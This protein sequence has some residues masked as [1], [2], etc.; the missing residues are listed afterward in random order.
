MNLAVNTCF[1]VKRWPDPKDWARLV[2]DWGVD[3]VQITTDHLD[4][5]SD[6]EPL[7]RVAKRTVQQCAA[8]GIQIL[9]LFHG[10]VRYQHPMLL[11][12][13]LTQRQEAI[14]L[15]MAGMR[16]AAQLGAP[17]FGAYLGAFGPSLSPA[18]QESRLAW[19]LESMIGLARLAS[20]M[21]LQG[22]LIEPTPV[23][24]E[25]PHSIAETEQWLGRLSSLEP[26][27][28]VELNLDLGHVCWS[29]G[30]AA[31]RDV[32]AWI[33]ALAARS[34][35]IHLQQTDG[36]LDRHWPFTETHQGMIDPMQMAA[37]IERA[38]PEAWGCL[39]IFHAPEAPDA[40]VLSDWRASVRVWRE[41]M[42]RGRQ[43]YTG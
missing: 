43:R 12:D 27:V 28:P 4:P 31:D 21:G 13:D 20:E 41:A 32:Y 25:Y 36:M 24:R 3:A 8:H 1:A 33:R 35:I 23:G 5:G 16:L 39:E 22:L 18:Q 10:L 9:C 15:W 2:A 38:A 34:P 37:A 6:P 11:A 7:Q 19:A 30:Q 14:A 42:A 26:A 17:Y 29:E 40:L